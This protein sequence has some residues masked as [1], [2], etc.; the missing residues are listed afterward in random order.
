V[1]LEKQIEVSK[2][3]I[4]NSIAQIWGEDNREQVQN[5]SVAAEPITDYNKA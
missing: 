3:K 2:L 1:N 4:Q 5:L